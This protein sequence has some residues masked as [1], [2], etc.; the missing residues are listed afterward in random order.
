MRQH[1]ILSH[2]IE[3]LF[4]HKIFKLLKILIP[5]LNQLLI[6][7]ITFHRTNKFKPLKTNPNKQKIIVSDNPLLL[8]LKIILNHIQ[9]HIVTNH[10]L[11]HL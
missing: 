6:K 8:R 3:T 10:I 2:S 5:I 11:K 4:P 7:Y 9:N 1:L